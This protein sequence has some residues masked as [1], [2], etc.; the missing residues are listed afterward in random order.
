MVGRRGGVLFTSKEQR[1]QM[2]QGSSAPRTTACVSNLPVPGC[3]GLEREEGCI[4]GASQSRP[5]LTLVIPGRPHSSLSFPLMP[6]NLHSLACLCH[7][8]CDSPL[9]PGRHAPSSPFSLETNHWRA[10]STVSHWTHLDRHFAP[11]T[12]QSACPSRVRLSVWPII[13]ENHGRCG[14]CVPTGGTKTQPASVG[15]R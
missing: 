11:T 13:D 5:P 3:C 2:K 8:H 4:T 6:L 12:S 9:L 14:V 7:S 1:M 10:E 15:C